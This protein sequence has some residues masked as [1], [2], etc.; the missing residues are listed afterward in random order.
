MSDAGVPPA[1]CTR[2]IK[3]LAWLALGLG[4]VELGLGEA[5]VQVSMAAAYGGPGAQECL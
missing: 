3:G 5:P 2:W 4:R 1:A